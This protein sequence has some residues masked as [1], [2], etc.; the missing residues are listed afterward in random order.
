MKTGGFVIP[1][2]INRIL[3]CCGLQI[4]KAKIG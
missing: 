4:R 2:S 1:L 3:A